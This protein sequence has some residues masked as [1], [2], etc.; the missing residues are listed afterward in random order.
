M[1]PY[2]VDGISS[3]CFGGYGVSTVNSNDTVL[4]TA[5]TKNT[6]NAAFDKSKDLIKEHK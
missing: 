3:P 6:D 2:N 1:L 5:P 4:D